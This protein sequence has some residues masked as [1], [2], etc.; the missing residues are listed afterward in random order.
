M[1]FTGLRPI[2]KNGLKGFGFSIQF[3]DQG[4]GNG[5][6]LPVETATEKQAACSD[7]PDQF[8]SQVNPSEPAERAGEAVL[9]PSSPATLSNP[10]PQTSRGSSL[11]DA[12]TAGEGVPASQLSYSG[13]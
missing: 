6:A 8:I 3:T 9:L 13:A 1:R 7:R 10:R 4:E 5:L 2:E 12:Q 11:P